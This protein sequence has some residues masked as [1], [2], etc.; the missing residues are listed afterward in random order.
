MI[1]VS[2]GSLSS[3]SPSA[4]LPAARTKVVLFA[5]LRAG[6]RDRRALVEELT[7]ALRE[8]RLEPV[9]CSE[10]EA[11]SE[12]AA[13]PERGDLRCV[14][15]VGGD[16]TLAEVL[17]RAPGLPV[18]VLPTGNENLVARYCRLERCSRSLAETI[19]A[20]RT[21]RMDLARLNGR[22]FSLM[23]GVGL[24]AEVV[25]RVHAARQGHINR[26]TYVWPTFQALWSYPFPLVQVDIEDSG[27][28]LSGVHVFVFNLPQYA[29]NLPLA[30]EAR[31]D[32]G[33]LDL[34]VFERP[35][36]GNLARYLA[37]VLGRRQRSLRDVKH[38]LVRRIRLSSTGAAPLQTDGDPAGVLPATI[39][40]VPGAFT[41]LVPGESVPHD[42]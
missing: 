26:L 21:R 19:A 11:L 18:A 30:R 27:E 14:V 20:G 22:L 7:A 13:G 36:I 28:R 37:T 39:E 16:G 23:A 24:D 32:D 40:V 10:R 34:L 4:P 41:L 29:L 2:N 3:Q 9:L 6:S 15:S 25:H 1:D 33:L 12:L 5:N 31:P 17:N 35:G 42:R 38:R 8:R